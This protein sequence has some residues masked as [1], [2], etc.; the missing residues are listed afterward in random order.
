MH[1]F[2]A[3]TRFT[4][5]FATG[6][7]MA[8]SPAAYA[9]DATKHSTEKT[10]PAASATVD[11]LEFQP[12]DHILGNKDAAVRIIEY[13]SLTCP[14]CRAYH[15]ETFPLIKEHYIDTGKVAFVYRHFPFNP[16]ALHGAA[17]AE[18]AGDEQFFKYINVLM[19]TQD[20]WAFSS[21]YMDSLRNIAA[22]GGMSSEAFDA[23]MDDTAKQ[24]AIAQDMAVSAKQLTINSTPTTFVNGEK[25]NG[26][27]E[28]ETLKQYIDPLLN[29]A[30]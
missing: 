12:G 15:M 20:K 29:N 1:K 25:F 17:L 18:C 5:T 27:Q 26:F 8:L 3:L 4:G 19:K 14:H 7:I 30:K 13:A 11:M 9:E 23:C 16:P 24:D 6:V 21:D 2:N 10:A 28:F 22:V